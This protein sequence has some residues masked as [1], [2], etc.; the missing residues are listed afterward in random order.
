M[1]YDIVKKTTITKQKPGSN[2][3]KVVGGWHPA[4]VSGAGRV[5]LG[6]NRGHDAIQIESWIIF[7]QAFL[8]GVAHDFGQILANLSGDIMYAFIINSSDK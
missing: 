1:N 7:N 2:G 5:M 8:Y 6:H 3:G 4:D